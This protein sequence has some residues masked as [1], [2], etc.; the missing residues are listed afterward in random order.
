MDFVI[1]EK[2]DS[3]AECIFAKGQELDYGLYSGE[4]GLLLFL[5]YYSRYS[6]I[7]K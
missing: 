7:K 5:Y 3:I 4:F 6:Q 2:I 1:K